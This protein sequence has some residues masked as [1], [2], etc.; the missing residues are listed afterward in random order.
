M[1]HNLGHKVYHAKNGEEAIQQYNKLK[2]DNTVVDIVLLDDDMP[3]MNGTSLTH[4]LTHSLTYSLLLTYLLTHSL[5]YLLIGTSCTMALRF[6][7]YDGLII[8]LTGHMDSSFVKAVTYCL[9]KP[10]C[11]ETLRSVVASSFDDSHTDNDF[12]I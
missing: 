8:G 5:T 7:G 4:P 11:I 6:A 9:P 2:M 3:I 12:V 1:L 10:L